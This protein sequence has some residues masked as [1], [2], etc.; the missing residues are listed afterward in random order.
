MQQSSSGPSSIPGRSSS[1][2]IGGITPEALFQAL[3]T[4]HTV[5]E[6]NRKIVITTIDLRYYCY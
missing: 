5:T 6:V 4:A 1:S 2:P 3:Q